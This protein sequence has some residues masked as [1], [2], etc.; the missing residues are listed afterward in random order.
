MNYSPEISK[1]VLNDRLDDLKPPSEIQESGGR[2]PSERTL[3]I[4][5]NV[6]E[7]PTSTSSPR[8]PSFHLKSI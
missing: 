5:I 2:R 1:Q 4:V 7:S 3:D 8:V 6:C